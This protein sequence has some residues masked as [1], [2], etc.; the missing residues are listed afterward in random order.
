MQRD[1]GA[2][3]IVDTDVNVDF[4]TRADYVE[5]A[6]Q[7]APPPKLETFADQEMPNVEPEL[8]SGQTLCCML[9]VDPSSRQVRP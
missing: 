7:P 8:P 9:T 2:I 3:S 1:H 6:R 4:D 5:P